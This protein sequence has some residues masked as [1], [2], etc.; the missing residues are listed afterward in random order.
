MA[1]IIRPNKTPEAIRTTLTR[2]VAAKESLNRIVE[3]INPVF[4]IS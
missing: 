1:R 4:L 3:I 2:P